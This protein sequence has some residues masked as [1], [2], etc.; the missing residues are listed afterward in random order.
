[1]F[2]G[3]NKNGEN[4]QDVFTRIIFKLMKL[5]LSRKHIYPV[6]D[7]YFHARNKIHYVFYAKVKDMHAC[8]IFP[9]DTVSWFTFK[10]TAKLTFDDQ[11]KQDVVVSERVINAAARES[12]PTIYPHRL[13]RSN[14]FH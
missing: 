7:Y 2:G 10:Q 3:L 9:S 13:Q 11:T 4:A 12:A 5:Q 6:Y 14:L 8:P 1:M